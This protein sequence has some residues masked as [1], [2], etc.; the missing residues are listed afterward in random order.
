MNPRLDQ[1][2][3]LPWMQTQNSNEVNHVTQLPSS[4]ARS[5]P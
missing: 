1:K 2:N 5:R 3:K 4:H